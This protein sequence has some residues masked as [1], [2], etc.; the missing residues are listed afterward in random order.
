[1]SR[2]SQTHKQS[3]LSPCSSWRSIGVVCELIAIG[4]AV[5]VAAGFGGAAELFVVGLQAV[6]STTPQ[7]M[8]SRPD[9][10]FWRAF[11]GSRPP[12]RGSRRGTRP[13]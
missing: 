11:Q 2:S 3:L 7:S 6:V 12:N 5:E 9:P 10:H 13:G 8:P 1:M 4:G